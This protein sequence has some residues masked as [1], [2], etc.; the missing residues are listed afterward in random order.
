MNQSKTVKSS[1]AK[2]VEKII[3]CHNYYNSVEQLRNTLDS[4]ELDIKNLEAR[5]QTIKAEIQI[6]IA[7]Q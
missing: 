6:L 4:F 1:L 5:V 2:V 3:L 7:E